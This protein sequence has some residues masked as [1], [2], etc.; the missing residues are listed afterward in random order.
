MRRRGFMAAAAAAMLAPV[1]ARGQG[2]APLVAFMGVARQSNHVEDV[3]GLRAGLRQLG[4]VEGRTVQIEERYADGSIERFGEQLA[5]MLQRRPAVLVVPGLAAA[6]EIRR[7]THDVPVVVVGLPS[8]VIYPDLFQSL[9][10][11]GGSITGFSHFGED[12]AV[13]RIELLREI[14]PGLQTVGVIHNTVDPLF[15]EWGE[16][17]EAA[18]RQQGLKA[19]RLGISTTSEAELRDQIDAGRAEGVQ[20]LA[21]VRDFFTATLQNQILRAANT[22]RLATIAER[23]DFTEAGGL[24]S[25]GA[26]FPDLFRRAAAYVDRI[27][28]GDRPAEMPIQL[29]TEFELGVNMRTATALGLAVPLPILARADVIIE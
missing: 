29:A 1:A 11:P 4:H 3:E 18:A 10:R 19:V 22:L 25:Y 26:R 24:L 8:S 7:Q 16:K 5:A 2:G 14:V 27:L 12:L 9:H 21:I 6:L 28:K 13:K 15:R 17:T 23:L 20:A